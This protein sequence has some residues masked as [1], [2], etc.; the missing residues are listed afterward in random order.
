MSIFSSVKGIRVQ[1]VK[2][3]LNRVIS[4]KLLEWMMW[5]LHGMNLSSVMFWL[6]QIMKL[7]QSEL[8]PSPKNLKVSDKIVCSICNLFNNVVGEICE[9]SQ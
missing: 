5:L 2:T 3:P 1:K 6:I 9:S 4:P 8:S 7:N